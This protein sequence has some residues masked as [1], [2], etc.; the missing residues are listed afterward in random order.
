MFL[1][2]LVAR[3]A[4]AAPDA[5]TAAQLTPVN[6]TTEVHAPNAIVTTDDYKHMQDTA[7]EVVTIRVAMV[8]TQ[9]A[10]TEDKNPGA[11][12]VEARAVVLGV[13][14]SATNLTVGSVIYLQ[15]G[16]IPAMPGVPMPP[17]TPLVK[18]N[19]EYRAYLSG[20]PGN[21]PYMPHAGAQSFVDRA[22]A[23]AS[24]LAVGPIANPSVLPTPDNPSPTGAV[25]VRGAA[26][27]QFAKVV[28]FDNKWGVS[29]AG[30][31]PIPLQTVG[32]AKP[33]LLVYYGP[34]GLPLTQP[35]VIIYQAGTQ[36]ATPPGKGDVTV[37]RALIL[38]GDK[39][40]LGDELWALRVG[41]NMRP[42]PLPIWHWNTYKV[43][44][45]DPDTHATKTIM[46]SGA[47]PPMPTLSP[48]SP[49]PSILGR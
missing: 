2:A 49:S 25:R 29:V 47:P 39:H 42:P 22:T 45:E 34:H 41:N 13:T 24:I 12:L 27:D 16:Y 10:Q 18:E 37:E 21:A 14:K 43:D 5:G 3:S 44:V 9:A 15:Y 46:L 26:L 35:T 33:V 36:P 8:K 31:D 48:P 40:R 1:F 20:G 19:A 7:P 11:L 23:D 28:P 17:A 4:D 38:D 6:V 30:G 32:D